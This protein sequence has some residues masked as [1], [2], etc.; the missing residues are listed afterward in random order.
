[1]KFFTNFTVLIVI[2][3][4]FYTIYVDISVHLIVPL[5]QLRNVY[6]ILSYRY[7]AKYISSNISLYKMPFPSFDNNNSHLMHKY[8]TFVIIVQ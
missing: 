7:F 4:S 8:C 3:G 1:M 6:D 2:V 5:K